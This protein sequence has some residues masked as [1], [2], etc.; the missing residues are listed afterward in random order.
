[1]RYRFVDTGTVTI[2]RTPK[3]SPQ[4]EPLAQ[5]TPPPEP[6]ATILPEMTVTAK[7]TDDTSYN[8][9]N[10]TTA[11]KTDTPIMETPVSIQVVPQ[12]IL[13][14][15]QAVRVQDA[16]KNVSG[17]QFTA[18][19]GDYYDSFN[20]REFA[21]DG[22]I[23]RFRNGRRFSG[24]FKADFANIEQVEVLKGPTAVLYGRIEPGGIVNLVIE[25]PLDQPYYALQ[26]QFGSYDF[27]R[28]TVDATGPI[29]E[30]KSLLYRFNLG[31]TD[32]QSFRDGKIDQA[33][34]IAPT[35]TWRPT[36]ATVINLS[37]EH[38]E[39]DLLYDSGIP[40]LVQFADGN[41]HI[42]PISIS[43]QFSEPGGID[44]LDYDLVDLNAYHRFR[45][46]DTDWTVSA[47]FNYHG[48]DYVYREISSDSVE[49]DGR[50]VRRFVYFSDGSPQDAYLTYLDLTGKFQ[51][52]ETE[53]TVLVGWDYYNNDYRFPLFIDRAGR[54]ESELAV[55]LFDPELGKVDVA[56]IEAQAPDRFD[57]FGYRWH[58]VYFQ[59]QITLW[60]KLHLLGGGR[61]DWAESFSGGSFVSLD[62][63]QE[64]TLRDEKFS[65]RVG[66]V[67]Q[68]WPWLS[69]YGNYVE[70]LGASGGRSADGSPLPPQEGE[71]Y[72]VGL[73][74]EFFDGR[75]SST[76]AFYHLT[77][78]NLPA[79]DLSTPERG[80]SIA[81]GEARSRGIEFD[82]SGQLTERLSVIGTYA[83]TDAEITKETLGGGLQ[84]PG[85]PG[86]PLPG[87]REHSGSLWAKYE[88]LPE[89]FEVGTGVF[90]AGKSPGILVDTPGYGRWDAF[91]AYHFRLGGSRLTAQVNVNNILDKEYFYPA[92]QF[93][94][95][96]YP[97]EPITVLGSI[98]V[99]Y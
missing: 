72:E 8:V 59:D 77:K 33:L 73:K 75:L 70:S 52:G 45:A 68:P 37:Y 3:A 18:G 46:L 67:Y 81:I 19:F 16:L 47:A 20:I 87:A 58:G 39:E 5:A 95:H 54:F 80:D 4:P 30:G 79:A 27:Y 13:K 61:Y 14:D 31:Y 60:G 56:A 9:P 89:R 88:I 82:I 44:E 74:T 90:F 32:T 12:Q 62:A 10:A 99:E 43:S 25:K 11:T 66:L 48:N 34:L 94:S 6:E 24:N 1:M 93:L 50:T 63:I 85:K 15:Q 91:A 23:D 17:V 40:I 69:L 97:G 57:R 84:Q 36:Q 92:Q 53:H 38:R 26:Q 42:P 41:N 49:A 65:P 76:L 55:D 28:T 78:A 83:L 22:F 96:I 64:D 29:D 86:D 2:E 51:L 71:Q 98:R 7:P 21:S 35:L